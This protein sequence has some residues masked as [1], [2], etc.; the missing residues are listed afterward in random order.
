VSDPGFNF[1]I[2]GSGAGGLVAAIAAKLAGLR[3]L[4]LE[5]TPL[6]GGSS[7]MSGGLL[8]LPN[9]PLMKREGVIDSREEALRYM[10]NFVEPDAVYSTPARREAATRTTTIRCL[11]ATRPGAPCR[12]SSTM[13]TG[14]G[15]GRRA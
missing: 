2:V 6:I 15:L 9:N 14:W 4:L 12:P 10:E 1:V 7:V 13:P 3:P 5:K 11:A 8:W